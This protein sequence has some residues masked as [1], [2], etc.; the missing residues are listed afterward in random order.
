MKQSRCYLNPVLLVLLVSMILSA[1]GERKT[2]HIVLEADESNDLSIRPEDMFVARTIIQKRFAALGMRNA[3]VLNSGSRQITA[4]FTLSEKGDPAW[5]VSA[6]VQT[7]LLEFVEMGSQHPDE[8]TIIQTDYLSAATEAPAASSIYHTVMT[9]SSL[10][11]VHVETGQQLG[12]TGYA[13][14]FTLN[15]EATEVFAEYTGNHIGQVL[16]IVMDKKVI[17]APT[18]NAKI[19]K[20]SAYIQGSFTEENATAL[21]ILM[22]YGALPIPVKVTESNVVSPAQ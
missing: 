9:G 17:S 7:G 6:I 11:T 2:I 22:R 19:E 18:I 4:D 20:G 13:I 3:K 14:A 8:G 15:P 12:T 16:A 21:A 1:C 10:A 5:V